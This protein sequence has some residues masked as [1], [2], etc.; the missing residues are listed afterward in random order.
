[1]LVSVSLPARRFNLLPRLHPSFLQRS[2][3]KVW[4]RGYYKLQDSL[5]MPLTSRKK[6]LAFEQIYCRCCTLTCLKH[7]TDHVSSYKQKNF[8]L[9]REQSEG[10]A[11]LITE[12]VA[13]VGPPH[14]PATGFPVQSKEALQA[15]AKLAWDKIIGLIGYFDLNTNRVLDVIID[16]FTTHVLHHYAFFLE[17]LRQSP[18]IRRNSRSQYDRRGRF[19]SNAGTEMDLDQPPRKGQ[20]EGL[21][22]DDVL[23]IAEHGSDVPDAVDDGPT[24]IL[25]QIL[26]F[27]FQQYQVRYLCLHHIAATYSTFILVPGEDR[28]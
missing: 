1:M 18:W 17:L 4:T 10:Y 2:V 6:P 24:P 23:R 22:F 16:I 19:Q 15:S 5:L 3:A 27:K 26:G 14:N 28:V 7:H 13:I 25:G 12:I 21:E 11:K 9:L 20:Y 8:N